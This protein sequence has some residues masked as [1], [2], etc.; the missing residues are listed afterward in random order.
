MP[1]T[2]THPR[3][4]ATA[5]PVARVTTAPPVTSA[6]VEPQVVGAGALVPLDDG[7]SVSYA[8]FDYAASAPCLEAVQEAITRALPYY[9]SVH[10]G[11]GYA[12]QVTTEAYEKARETVRTFLGAWERD[13]VVFTRNTTDAMN[14]LAHAVPAGTTVVVFETEHH[15]TLLPWKRAVRLPAPASP[16]EAVSA[17]DRAL[18]EA[19][20]GP[21]LLVVTAASNVTGELWP[22]AE[23][24]Q[25]ARR[26]GA[27]IAVDA[28]Q[29]VPH[30]P[31]DMR[32]LGLDY[33]AFSGHK[34][35]APFGAGVLAG[36][37][38]W[39][40]AAEPYLKGGGA[41]ASVVD[42]G[43]TAH[44][45]KSPETRH[46][47]GTPNVLG[48]IAIAAA[49]EALAGTGWDSLVREEERLLA[50]LRQ[51][52]AAIPGVRELT[53]WGEGNARVGIVSLVV[54]GWS[55]RDVALRL[56]GE[57]GI[58]VRDGKFCAHPFVRHLLGA[59]E[60]AQ[61]NA[62]GGCGGGQDS[63]VRASFGIGTTDEHVDRL[64]EALACIAG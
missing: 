8:N 47:A 37:A 36:R 53:L 31:L 46:E 62:G 44:W 12:S 21:R 15:A 28:A 29:L 52:I 34:L 19:P 63:A 49:C 45:A 61:R 43:D 23:L 51:G 6:A 20:A 18:A 14:L 58:G 55:A 41:S 50:R 38:D 39:L 30:R 1:A 56:S 24:A 10:R 57:Y 5:V 17:A 25:V 64:L 60:T 4:T 3:T 54:D 42:H 35:Y 9:S 48:V 7:G 26:H 11:A 13:A 32:A 59:P 16:L 2:L 33:V 27:R 40:R 22:I